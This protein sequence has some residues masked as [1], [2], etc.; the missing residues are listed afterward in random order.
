[1]NVIKFLG[2]SCSHSE[3]HAN[4][5]HLSSI[6]Y[7]RSCLFSSRRAAGYFTHLVSI[8]K[9]T[10]DISSQ[11]LPWQ[12][13]PSCVSCDRKKTR[14]EKKPVSVDVRSDVSEIYV[15]LYLPFTVQIESDIQLKKQNNIIKKF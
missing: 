8:H 5:M 4:L 11:L 3:T 7:T 2:Q 1:M 12:P 9:F 13:A 6:K 10:D 14:R 15:C